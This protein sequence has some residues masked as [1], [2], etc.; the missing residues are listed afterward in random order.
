LTGVNQ[1]VLI[2][3]CYTG[4]LD[5]FNAL[6]WDAQDEI[7]LPFILPPPLDNVFVR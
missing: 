3:E 5:I 4:G 1:F 2:A 7:L 6:Y